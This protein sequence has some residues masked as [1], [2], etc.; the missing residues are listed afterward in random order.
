MNASHLNLFYCLERKAHLFFLSTFCVL[1]LD[2]FVCLLV[3]GDLK[4][5][6]ASRLVWSICRQCGVCFTFQW[7]VW[8]VSLYIWCTW[9]SVPCTSMEF[10]L[11]F[12]K[13]KPVVLLN[14]SK[15]SPT[16]ISKKYT[17]R[18]HKILNKSADWFCPLDIH[19]NIYKFDIVNYRLRIEKYMK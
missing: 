18:K 4:S 19:H 16:F 6:M 14:S 3:R 1:W 8:G 15:A 17:G 5:S 10:N 2:M 12:H 13:S 9:F 7:N 11:H